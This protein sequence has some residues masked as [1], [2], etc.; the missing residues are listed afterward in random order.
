MVHVAAGDTTGST[1][2]GRLSASDA[3]KQLYVCCLSK[4]TTF[5]K[6]AGEILSA[7]SITVYI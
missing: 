6:G 2:N 1:G 4:N 7:Q 3:V 5:K